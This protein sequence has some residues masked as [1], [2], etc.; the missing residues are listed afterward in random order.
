MVK[1]TFEEVRKF[2]MA[3]DKFYRAKP[4]NEQTK[5]GY[6]VRKV[7][8]GSIKQIVKDY[9]QAYTEK[10]YT[11]VESVQV[12]NALTDKATGAILM[13]PKGSDRPYQYK[14]ENLKKVMI[15]E[16]KF[17]EITASALLDEWDK[18]EFEIDEH[19]ASEIPEG[20]SDGD[21]EAFRGFAIDPNMVIT[22]KKEVV[23][24]AS[25]EV[26]E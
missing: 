17:A 26:A 4:T 12:D 13:A 23:E 11:E 22:E 16:R 18:K 7:S 15:A 24:S 5:L 14:P 9:Q 2:N 25:A 20:L 6:A 19:Y 3:V 1:K 21:I 10:Y 8:E